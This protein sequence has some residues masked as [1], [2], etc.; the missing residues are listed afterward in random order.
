MLILIF[1]VNV[2][3]G[4]VVDRLNNNEGVQDVSFLH[5]F[6]GCSLVLSLANVVAAATA[7]A[8]AAAA[9]FV[10]SSSSA[11]LIH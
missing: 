3:V 10:L 1:V 11:L 4:V 5:R 7:A 9:E 8:A 6:R 2:G